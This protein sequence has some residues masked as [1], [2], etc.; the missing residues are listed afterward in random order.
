MPALLR[1]EI[2]KYISLISLLLVISLI[3]A[4]AIYPSRVVWDVGTGSKLSFEIRDKN[5]NPNIDTIVDKIIS[6]YMLDISSKVYVRLDS[7]I[8]TVDPHVIALCLINIT[9]PYNISVSTDNREFKQVNSY[10][11]PIFIPKEY[12]AI[13]K[14]LSSIHGV[15]FQS[16]KYLLADISEWNITYK[17]NGG[18]IS[19]NMEFKKRG[20]LD[21]YEIIEEQNGEKESIFLV[22]AEPPK[23]NY[24]I[25]LNTSPI[26]N[27][28]TLISAIIT[29]IFGGLYLKMKI[30]EKKIDKKDLESIIERAE[31]YSKTYFITWLTGSATS[32]VIGISSIPLSDYMGNDLPFAAG[33]LY[34]LITTIALVLFLEKM[35]SL[36]KLTINFSDKFRAIISPTTP[37]VLFTFGLVF[38]IFGTS[39][40][41]ILLYP[42][43]F[44]LFVILLVVVIIFIY[45]SNPNRELR[46]FKE[47]VKELMSGL[48]ESK[49]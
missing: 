23:I 24:I 11:L 38:G 36:H 34:A 17:T 18:K 10:K 45:T 15:N 41:D 49:E 25:V 42:V 14:A 26:I 46:R 47:K 43:L 32:L 29:G 7:E 16:K 13:E 5:I 44:V 39:S 22:L 12:D 33:L 8:E 9:M 27:L 20:Y 48:N 37:I 28:I 40:R 3:A 35:I 31:K 21:S 2:Y 1:E 30:K 6:T 19:I 4:S